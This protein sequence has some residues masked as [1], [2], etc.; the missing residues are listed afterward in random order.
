MSRWI[1]AILALLV[2][3]GTDAKAAVDRTCLVSLYVNEG[4]SPE[5]KRK[6]TFV[7][8]LELIRIKLSSKYDLRE[9][10]ALIW[11]ES[12]LPIVARIDV[13]IIGVDREF[14]ADDFQRTFEQAGE[15]QATQL[16]GEGRNL[17]WRIK[18]KTPGGWVDPEM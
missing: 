13:T 8:G 16:E 3:T 17:K 5:R 18:A 1:A 6:I 15:R 9:H 7:T 2:L 14:S 11:L 10:Y 4:W 12:G